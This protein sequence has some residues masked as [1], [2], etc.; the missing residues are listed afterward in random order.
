MREKMFSFRVMMLAALLLCF[1]RFSSPKPTIVFFLSPKQSTMI[2]PS[3]AKKLS[4]CCFSVI[5]G[6]DFRV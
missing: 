1:A 3:A 4:V 5:N 2:H 6:R